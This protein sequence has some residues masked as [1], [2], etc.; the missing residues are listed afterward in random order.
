MTPDNPHGL[1]GSAMYDGLNV[2]KRNVALNLKHP[3]AVASSS[4][5]SSSGPTRSPRTTR[6]GR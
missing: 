3:E 2:G 1:E 6:R 5:S 4:A